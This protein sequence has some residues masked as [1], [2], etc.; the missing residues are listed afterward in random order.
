MSEQYIE[1]GT[2]VVCTNMTIPSPLKIGT[3]S[4]ICTAL[5]KEDKP[6][7]RIV[8]T[9]ISNCF[10]CRVP[11]MKWGGVIASL[12]GIAV[13]ALVVAGAIALI[14][15]TIATGGLAGGIVAG[16]GAAVLPA[17]EGEIAAS[18]MIGALTF[19]GSIFKLGYDLEHLCDASLDATWDMGLPSTII[20]GEKAILVRSF[21]P[22]PQGGIVTL[23]IDDGLAEQAA[24]MIS[25]RN[26]EIINQEYLNQ[27]IQGV[28][29][30]ATGGATPTAMAVSAFF[31]LIDGFKGYAEDDVYIDQ[32]EMLN[33]DKE[34]Q[35][36]YLEKV[37]EEGRN[38]AIGEGV[39]NKKGEGTYKDAK[40]H[41]GAYK[42]SKQNEAKAIEKYQKA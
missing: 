28:I 17:V 4:R 36:E 5:T 15:A 35:Y 6:V 40:E 41:M 27:F 1:L 21:I 29:S 2:N 19:G 8:D 10:E 24:R 31:T 12:F 16:I 13:G 34:F 23:I 20:E 26:H 32:Y 25:D 7:L 11:Q 38:T 18:V 14:T 3:P 22:C 42:E 39:D 9:K 30:G 37:K 33:R